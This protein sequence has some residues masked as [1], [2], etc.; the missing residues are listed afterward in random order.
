MTV[1]LKSTLRSTLEAE[2]TVTQETFHNW[3]D[4]TFIAG[5]VMVTGDMTTQLQGLIDSSQGVSDLAIALVADGDYICDKIT[6]EGSRCLRVYGNNATIH[7]A[8]GAT[9]SQWLY[10]SGAY[11]LHIENVF[12]DGNGSNQTENQKSFIE[13]D[14]S[15]NTGVVHFINCHWED[16]V[17]RAVL[18]TDENTSLGTEMAVFRRCSFENI[19]NGSMPQNCLTFGRCQNQVGIYGCTFEDVSQQADGNVIYCSGVIGG[20]TG[21]PGSQNSE[22]MG[23]LTVKDVEFRR[24]GTCVY[25]QAYRKIMLSNLYGLD[26]GYTQDSGVY[27]ANY[28]RVNNAGRYAW[29]VVEESFFESNTTGNR[30]RIWFGHEWPQTNYDHD[31]PFIRMHGVRV[32]TGDVILSGAYGFHD[33]SRVDVK[34]GRLQV[35]HRLGSGMHCNQIAYCTNPEIHSLAVVG[36]CVFTPGIGDNI[37]GSGATGCL[38]LDCVYDGVINISGCPHGTIYGGKTIN[39]G[40]IKLY[41]ENTHFRIHNI[42]IDSSGDHA[43][44]NVSDSMSGIEI[45]NCQLSSNKDTINLKDPK[46]VYITNN[47]FLRGNNSIVRPTQFNTFIGTIAGNEGLKKLPDLTNATG[48]YVAKNGYFLNGARIKLDEQTW[49]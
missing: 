8:S 48:L 22:H 41:G 27:S 4:T 49:Q 9:D 47:T 1:K 16:V 44:H 42:S 19:G 3:I 12:F 15:A 37:I 17:N 26:Q 34:N 32:D 13:Y 30:P 40:Y 7:L 25:G 39:G 36:N 43:I 23:F 38:F 35:G 45:K 46:E 20:H 33:V 2:D 5:E 10:M 28:V 18:L 31:V 11:G 21:K 24:T 6:W 14:T 29:T